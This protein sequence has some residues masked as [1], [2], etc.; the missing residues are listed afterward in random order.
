MNFAWTLLYLGNII[1]S[2][3][4]NKHHL[5]PKQYLSLLI[6]VAWTFLT[7]YLSLFSR[8]IKEKLI[9]FWLLASSNKYLQPRAKAFWKRESWKNR[10]KLQQPSFFFFLF[11]LFLFFSSFLFFPQKMASFPCNNAL[12]RALRDHMAEWKS[13]SRLDML[14]LSIFL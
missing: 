10:K 14:L 5:T 6:S 1:L 12:L 8:M 3:V 9:G 2:F 4:A 7:L 13:D 11:Y